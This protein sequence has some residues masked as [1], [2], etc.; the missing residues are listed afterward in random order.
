MIK[1][2]LV[3]MNK[4]T[5][6]LAALKTAVNLSKLFRARLY[7]LYVEDIKKMAAAI[8]G[9]SP[10]GV[11]LSLDLAKIGIEKKKLE[12]EIQ[13]EMETVRGYYDS[14]KKDIE[15]GHSLTV[16]TGNITKELLKCLKVVDLV[17]MG[18]AF[19]EDKSGYIE[20]SIFKVLSK[21]HKPVI[22][23]HDGDNLG[24]NILI[25]YDGSLEA[26]IGLKIVADFIP[27]LSPK[28]TILSVKN[29]E[30]DAEPI[31]K[32]AEKYFSPHDVNIEKIWK[33]G[34][35]GEN[36]INTVEEKNISFVVMGT[37]G[38]DKIK[39][40]LLGETTRKVIKKLKVPVML[41]NT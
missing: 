36:I 38:E 16:R 29:K 35:A 28:I 10:S 20:N 1:S 34:K 3:P 6:S 5:S 4:S 30:K 15:T 7:L 8:I 41:C 14:V 11:G 23:V 33:R 37:G 2:I 27:L 19:K 40:L 32:E 13:I 25:A 31:L 12:K 18:Q 22:T 9:K 39:D 26:N 17:V 21:S 24:N